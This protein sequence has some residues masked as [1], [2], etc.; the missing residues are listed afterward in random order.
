MQLPPLNALRAFHPVLEQGSLAAAAA[1][2][3]IVTSIAIS[4]QPGNTEKVSVSSRDEIVID[5]GGVVA[6]ETILAERPRSSESEEEFSVSTPGTVRVPASQAP[7]CSV[8]WSDR[9]GSGRIDRRPLS[10][11]S[12][13]RRPPARHPTGFCEKLT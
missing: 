11:I 5:L 3:L 12:S 4:H 6:D 9:A 7:C 10:R 2:E 1:A 8:G 13:C